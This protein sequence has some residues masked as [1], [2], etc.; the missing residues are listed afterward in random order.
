MLRAPPTGTVGSSDE[1]AQAP[2]DEEAGMKKVVTLLL[3]AAVIGVIVA[4]V[5]K[6][7]EA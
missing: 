3:I 2:A 7:T 5:R 4:V 1:V 6:Q